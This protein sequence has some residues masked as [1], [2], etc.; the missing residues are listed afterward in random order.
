MAIV[1]HD[2]RNPLATIQMAVRFLLEDLT[3]DDPAQ[4]PGRAQL[5]VIHRSAERMSR[6]VHDLLDVS[7]LEAGRLPMDCSPFDAELLIAD[8]VEL[9]GPLAASR[10][11]ALLT[12]TESALPRVF[13][14]RERILQVFSN[15]GGNAMKFTPGGGSIEI[16]AALRDG[17]VEFSV[18][19]TGAGISPSDLPH[20]FDRFWQAAMTKRNGLGLGLAIVYGIVQAHGGEIHVESSPGHGSMF[21]FTLPIRRS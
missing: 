20:I 19:D 14:D 6:M 16:G 3:P 15:L 11:I 8:A 17:V 7:A 21:R 18:R 9:L 12:S 4:Q 5:R 13:A 1:S 10:R 2:L